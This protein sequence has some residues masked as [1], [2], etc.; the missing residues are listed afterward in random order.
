MS[1]RRAAGFSFIELMASLAI[2][3]VLLL[4]AVPAARMATQRYREAELRTAL[5][6]IRGAIDRYKR[7]AEQGRVEVESGA[8]GYPPDLTVLVEGVEDVSTP[9]RKQLY[10]LRR[11]PRDP[12][13]AGSEASPEDTWGLRSYD[14]PPD[15]PAPGDDVFDVHSL[16]DGVGLNGVAYKDW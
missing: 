6:Q 8:S 2:M 12:F 14:S 7:A 15:D 4:I 3:A 5:A 16:S 10:F 13:Y 11:L 9:E 1:R